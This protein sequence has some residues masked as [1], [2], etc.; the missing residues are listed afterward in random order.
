MY[1]F[2]LI[3]ATRY[4]ILKRNELS[5]ILALNAGLPDGVRL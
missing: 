2:K 1:V 4:D 5:D 3:V